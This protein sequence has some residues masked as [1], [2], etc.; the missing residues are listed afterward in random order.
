MSCPERNTYLKQLNSSDNLEPLRLQALDDIEQTLNHPVHRAHSDEEYNKD[1]VFISRDIRIKQYHYK[2]YNR[3]HRPDTRGHYHQSSGKIILNKGKWCR[4]TIIHETLHSISILSNEKYI[5]EGNKIRFLNEA[6]T[7]FLTGLV[8]FRKYKN[9]CFNDWNKENY[10]QW[11]HVSY[12]PDPQILCALSSLVSVQ[13]FIKLYLW[14]PSASWTNRWSQFS[15]AIKN[16]CPSFED[17]YET[18]KQSEF[19]I[20]FK[21]ELTEK[22]GKKF[23]RKIKI[24]NYNFILP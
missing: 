24:F 20:G 5:K 8:L 3:I 9:S 22:L 18:W 2:L 17:K 14:T 13:E 16:A 1:V 12:K 21:N 10:K 4:K 11:C 7:E 23:R 15:N 6:L 19:M